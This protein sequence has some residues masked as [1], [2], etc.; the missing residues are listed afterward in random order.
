MWKS[1]K[2]TRFLACLLAAAMIIGLL[3]GSFLSARAADANPSQTVTTSADNAA[4]GDSSSEEDLQES[5]DAADQSASSDTT[6]S[7][8]SGVLPENSA[9]AEEALPQETENSNEAQTV[10][11]TGIMP[12]AV[13]EAVNWTSYSLATNHGGATDGA[14]TPTDDQYV[15]LSLHYDEALTITDADALNASLLSAGMYTANAG[16]K[17]KSIDASLS[18]D[19]KTLIINCHI[20]FAPFNGAL[21]V[22][23][24]AALDGIKTAAG[25]A[26]VRISAL[27]PVPHVP[28]GIKYQT[29]DQTPATDTVKASVTTKVTIPS[30]ATRAMVHVMLLKNGLPAYELNANHAN[31]ETHDHDYLNMTAAKYLSMCYTAAT[32]EKAASGWFISSYPDYDFATSGD[33]ITV[34]AKNSTAGDVLDLRLVAYPTD[35]DTEA[36]KTALNAAISKAAGLDLSSCSR[37]TGDALTKELAISRSYAASDNYLQSEIDERTASLNTAISA[38]SKEPRTAPTVSS[39]SLSGITKTGTNFSIRFNSDATQEWAD[40]VKSVSLGG[41]ALEKS[42]YAITSDTTGATLVINRTD[43]SPVLSGSDRIENAELIV[44]ASG[45][46]DVSATI[47]FIN[48]GASTFQVRYV[49]GDGNIFAV[50]TYTKEEMKAME[51]AGDAYYQTICGMAGLRTFKARGVLLTNLLGNAD[52]SF[53]SGMSLQVR[54]N[55][56]AESEND[57]TTDNAYYRNGNFT[58][59]NLMGQS[60]YYFPSVYNDPLR[61]SLLN[62]KKMDSTTRNLIGSSSGKTAVTPMLALDYTET[63]FRSADGAKATGDYSS[64]ISNERSY[65]FLFGLALDPADSSSIANETTTWSATYCAFGID[66]IN[67]DG[68]EKTDTEALIGAI[69]TEAPYDTAKIKAAR[70]AYDALPK[71]IQSSISNYAALTAAEEAAAI[72]LESPTVAGAS[73]ILPYDAVTT[74]ADDTLTLSV[75]PITS[76]TDYDR[77]T[78]GLSS[79]E[80]DDTFIYDIKLLL[81]GKEIEPDKPI[82]IHLPAPVGYDPST[83]RIFHI[84]RDGTISEITGI[85]VE[86]GIMTFTVDSLSDFAVT[87]SKAS[88][89]KSAASVTDSG[90]DNT[91]VSTSSESGNVLKA[92]STRTSD[93]VKTSDSSP[94]TV[95]AILLVISALALT[96]VLRYRRKRGNA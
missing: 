50:R 67:P 63:I 52:V 61:T 85:T 33:T 20:K 35:R 12:E 34:T 49:D 7:L 48:Y 77:I 46:L 32:D 71:Y 66:I 36:D 31:C 47:P 4:A 89:D 53:S 18:Q 38:L 76:G 40:S 54:T 11:D 10:Q 93:S 25:G 59:E 26:P 82:V 68:H 84:L 79:I 23:D 72:T 60:R 55:D 22:P 29:T 27:T 15:I 73:A 70:E 94:I 14:A 96:F 58:Y 9:D 30:S 13:G 8:K 87:A 75:T 78:T 1:T 64:L 43:D 80:K 39:R 44:K 90:S 37:S 88:S 92:S 69:G 51:Q 83:Y 56:C 42:Q 86:N 65:R 3:P 81:N 57:S 16:N 62:G 91:S 45:Y 41:I 6:A 28:N 95:Y 74:G 5:S 24:I 19:C 21:N 17:F 2:V